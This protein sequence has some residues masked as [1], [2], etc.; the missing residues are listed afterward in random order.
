VTKYLCQIL[1]I[2]ALVV[3]CG[4]KAEERRIEKA[5]EKATGAKTD[6]DL[7]RKRMDIEGK[8]GDAEYKMSIGQGAEMPKDFPGDVPVYKPSTVAAAM[9]IG[10]GHSLS[11][12]TKDSQERVV[13]A[14]AKLMEGEGWTVETSMS[15]GGQKVSMYKKGDRVANVG[16][17][18]VQGETQINL[19]VVRQ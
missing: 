17:A 7:S 14:Y 8:T 12:T 1:V 9:K 4:R 19:T 2:V 16:I 6:V 18:S 5:V 3:G 11:L 15:M 13:Q 10:D